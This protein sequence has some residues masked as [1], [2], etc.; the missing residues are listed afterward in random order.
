[1]KNKINIIGLIICIAIIGCI[2][3]NNY[4]LLY[5]Y[6]LFNIPFIA[7]YFYLI[8]GILD[9][10]QRFQTYINFIKKNNLIKKIWKQK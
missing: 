4:T 9:R 5:Y 1:M 10:L 2:Q 6:P 7:V 3:Y 8:C